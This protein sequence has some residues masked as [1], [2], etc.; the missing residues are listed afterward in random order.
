MA[1]G[2]NVMSARSSNEIMKSKI[3]EV[4]IINEKKERK[5]M[6]SIISI[7][8]IMAISIISKYQIYEEIINENVKIYQ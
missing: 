2:S 1:N 5:K 4:S 3:N 6:K 8:S 7:M